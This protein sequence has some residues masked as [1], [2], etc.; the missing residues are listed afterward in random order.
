MKSIRLHKERLITFE[1]Y[2]HTCILRLIAF[3]KP[4]EP[5]P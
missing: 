1:T 4:I 5:V 2:T 3:D